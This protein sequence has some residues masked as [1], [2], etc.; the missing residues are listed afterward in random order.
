MPM[1]TISRPQEKTGRMM[2]VLVNWEWEKRR[3]VRVETLAEFYG[4]IAYIGNLSVLYPIPETFEGERLYK[5]ADGSCYI[6]GSTKAAS[7]E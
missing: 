4:D 5:V 3:I 6:I 1:I 2:D 7:A